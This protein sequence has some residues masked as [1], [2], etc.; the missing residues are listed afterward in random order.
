MLGGISR[1]GFQA[2]ANAVWSLVAVASRTVVAINSIQYGSITLTDP[3]T[4][5][6]ATITSVTT[7]KAVLL[8]LGARTNG[9]GGTPSITLTNSTT[10]TATRLDGASGYTT[11]VSFVVLEF[12]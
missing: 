10:V 5:D 2:A 4:S 12:L 3:E 11:V 6:T 8:F 9:I 1:S 7:S